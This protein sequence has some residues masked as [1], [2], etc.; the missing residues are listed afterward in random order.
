[1]TNPENTYIDIHVFIS[2]I[3]ISGVRMAEWSREPD[4][5]IAIYR[6]GI[7]HFNMYRYYCVAKL[8]HHAKH[9][10]INDS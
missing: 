1:M 6:S 10:M 3:A 5:N 4:S 9:D 7:I 8:I 2:S